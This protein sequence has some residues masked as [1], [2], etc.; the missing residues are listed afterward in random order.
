MAL[1]GAYDSFNNYADIWNYLNINPTIGLP[2]DAVIST[3][4]RIERI[5][6]GINKMWKSGG[7]P[8]FPLNRKS[9]TGREKQVGMYL[10][11]KNMEDT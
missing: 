10:R 7:D 4:G 8:H 9:K 3:E 2:S 5:N 11:N 6:Y 1:D